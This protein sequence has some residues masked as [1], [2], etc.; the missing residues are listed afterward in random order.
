MSFDR[1][2]RFGVFEL[3]GSTGELR[4]AGVRVR[5]ARQAATLLQLLV[6]RPGDWSCG[7]SFNSASGPTRTSNASAA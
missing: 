6:E 7:T 5:L 3:R 1:I 2:Y 4:R